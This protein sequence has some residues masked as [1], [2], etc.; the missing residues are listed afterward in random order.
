MVYSK[1]AIRGRLEE[2]QQ[3]HLAAT[4]CPYSC[5][6]L[7]PCTQSAIWQIERWRSARWHAVLPGVPPPGTWT[8]PRREIAMSKRTYYRG[9]D[10]VVTDRH[11]VWRT[12]PAKGF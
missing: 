4:R 2:V 7:S 12:T 6:P 11:F 3:G 9:P 8:R 1:Q 10:A 5:L